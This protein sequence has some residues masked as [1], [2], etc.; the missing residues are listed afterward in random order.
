MQI[1]LGNR[2]VGIEHRPY[3]IADIAAN[4]DGDLSR[5]KDLVWISKEA[6]AD[7]AKFQHFLADKIVND[8][9]FQK[10]D[11]LKTHQSDWKNQFQ[12]FTMNITF[13]VS[14]LKKFTKNA[15]RLK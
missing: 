13:D 5:A 7:C 6:G 4:H 11:N 9:E 12:K 3:F 15:S 10:L 14:G 2:V 8:I 1:K